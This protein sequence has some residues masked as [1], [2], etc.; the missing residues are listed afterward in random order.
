MSSQSIRE[1]KSWYSNH[2]IYNKRPGR[3]RKLPK[4]NKSLFLCLD[5]F[6][7]VLLLQAS[8]RCCTPKNIPKAERLQELFSKLWWQLTTETV[9]LCQ[10]KILGDFVGLPVLTRHKQFPD[11]L[12]VWAGGS[13]S[14]L[15]SSHPRCC[16]HSLS[17][18]NLPGIPHADFH[19]TTWMH[20][21][22]A[23][24]SSETLL[25]L[26]HFHAIQHQC[27]I[28]TPA[29]TKQGW[30]QHPSFPAIPLLQGLLTTLHVMYSP[31]TPQFD[32]MQAVL[33]LTLPNTGAL[34]ENHI[35]VQ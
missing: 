5:T 2:S 33:G 1:L 9:I 16:K 19:C 29:N 27:G 20:S 14:S 25:Y 7:T 21:L 8:G 26:Y 12:P 34:E 35:A 10:N 22:M 18:G 31:L 13:C 23:L 28:Q 6:Y 30:L 11:Q 24:S 15:P 3:S 32:F 17:Q 4:E